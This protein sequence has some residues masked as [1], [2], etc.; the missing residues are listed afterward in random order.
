MGRSRE[1]SHVLTS[2]KETLKKEKAKRERGGGE[3]RKGEQRHD[4]VLPSDNDQPSGVLVW[5][6]LVFCFFAFFYLSCSGIQKRWRA[7][8]ACSVY[9]YMRGTRSVFNEAAIKF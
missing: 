9:T 7:S 4:S 5:S 2:K 6:T 3:E 1:K 8:L